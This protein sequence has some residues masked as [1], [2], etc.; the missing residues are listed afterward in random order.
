MSVPEVLIVGELVQ[1]G[2]YPEDAI[3]AATDPRLEWTAEAL[4]GCVAWV[5][6]FRGDVP[7]GAMLWTKYL[8][9]GWFPP[10]PKAEPEVLICP[11]CKQDVDDCGGVHGPAESFACVDC[12]KPL[13]ICRGRC[14]DICP[15]CGG[16][17]P[18]SQHGICAYCD[19]EAPS[20]EPVPEPVGV[21]G[22]L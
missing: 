21:G 10:M 14:A 12:G 3:A 15:T 5:G 19:P 7:G 16:V 22:E 9:A 20:A 6:A 13:R 8:K 11:H 1:A 17:I 2:V 4:A 18:A